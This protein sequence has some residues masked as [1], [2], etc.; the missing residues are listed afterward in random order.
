MLRQELRFV[1]DQL[2]KSDYQILKNSKLEHVQDQLTQKQEERVRQLKLDLQEQIA[3]MKQQYLTHISE[4]ESQHAKQRAEDQTIMAEQKQTIAR[5]EVFLKE[6]EDLLR[7]SQAQVEVLTK[8]LA[9]QEDRYKQLLVSQEESV[10]SQVKQSQM[11]LSKQQVSYARKLEDLEHQF[12]SIA[13]QL[14]GTRQNLK[15]VE[16]ERTSQAK[17]IQDYLL[18]INQLKAKNAD[19]EKANKD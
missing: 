16:S 3:K 1:S 13:G 7:S 12:K 11:E 14:D 2:K 5:L 9:T 8:H 15:Q 18:A 10:N 4:K 6:K 19:L 17:Q